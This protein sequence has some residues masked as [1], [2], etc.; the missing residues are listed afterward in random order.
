MG[1][2]S[3]AVNL[4]IFCEDQTVHLAALNLLDSYLLS[5]GLLGKAN[6][7]RESKTAL[8]LLL[9]EDIEVLDLPLDLI[10][11][12]GLLLGGWVGRAGSVLE[13]WQLI[14]GLG[15]WSFSITREG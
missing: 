13:T 6:L 14:H 7:L 4:P 1:I 2:V 9:H 11:L 15:A 3:K 10:V 12:D 8:H 5:V